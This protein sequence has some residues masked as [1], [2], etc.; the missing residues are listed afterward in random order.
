[1]NPD[2][3]EDRKVPLS[4]I[5]QYLLNIMVH[6]CDIANPCLEWEGYMKWSYMLSQEFQ[7]QTLKEEQLGLEVT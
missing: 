2:S 1:M 4:L 7:D 6:A 3:Y 5:C